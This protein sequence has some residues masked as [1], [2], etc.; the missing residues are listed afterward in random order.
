MSNNMFS[1]VFILLLCLLIALCLVDSLIQFANKNSPLR[2]M[3]QDEHEKYNEAALRHFRA[4]ISLVCILGPMLIIIGTAFSSPWL[5]LFGSI[6]CGAPAIFEN[7]F[8]KD[9]GSVFEKRAPNEERETAAETRRRK[10]RC[11]WLGFAIVVVSSFI[12]LFIYAERDPRVEIDR[13]DMCMRIIGLHGTQVSLS[14]VTDVTLFEDNMENIRLYAPSG[15]WFSGN[16]YEALGAKKGYFWEGLLYVQ[17]RTSPTIRIE[18]DRV[19][20]IAGIGPIPEATLPHNI[21]ISFRDPEATRELY[22]ELVKAL[23]S[24]IKED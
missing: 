22:A 3:R 10:E 2:R 14:R 5:S 7:K 15:V 20:M 23:D 11:L 19:W 17:P 21:F 6:I 9:Y 16:S 8:M 13:F 24:N 18:Y 12:A 4:K 1:I